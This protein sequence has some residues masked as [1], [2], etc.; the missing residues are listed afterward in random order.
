PFED[1]AML[2][3]PPRTVPFAQRDGQ[4][5]QSLLS[6][7]VA[8]PNKLFDPASV[9]EERAELVLFAAACLNLGDKHLPLWLEQ[10]DINDY[11][12]QQLANR[13]YTWITQNSPKFVYSQYVESLI[14]HTPRISPR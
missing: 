10:D 6:A 7:T 11:F 3:V 12:V 8:M 1:L 2:P 13:A 14:A 5:L 9:S 4:N